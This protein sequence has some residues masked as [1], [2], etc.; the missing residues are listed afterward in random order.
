M[1]GKHLFALVIDAFIGI[2]C[3]FA[4]DES[5][6][7]YNKPI[8]AITFRGLN[9]IKS[10]DLE[11][12]THAFIGK[13]FDDEVFSDLLNRLFALNY[14]ES[15]DPVPY[16]GD[17][18][19]KTVKIELEVVEYPVVSKLKI[20]GYKKIRG[21]EIR[22]AISTKE[23]SI[24]DEDKRFADEQVIRN[25]YIS[26]GFSEAKVRSEAVQSEDGFSVTFTIKEGSQTVVKDIVFVGNTIATARTLKSKLSS[27]VHHLFQ[28]GAFQDA[29]IEQDKK[30]IVQ[31]YA[32]NG[33][34]DAKVLNASQS[35]EYNEKN[36][37]QEVTLQ[38]NIYE[39]SQYTY[40]GTTIQG[41]LVFSTDELLKLI[42]LKTGAVFNATKF[43]EGISA[44]QDKYYGSGYWNNEFVPQMER[45]SN[46]KVVS[47][48]IYIGEGLRSHVEG[49][50]I[51]GNTRTRDEVIRREIPIESGDV[52]SNE[53]INTAMRN[54]YNLQYFK[55]VIP[56]IKP[57][58]EDNL[59]IVEFSVEE[60][61]TRS[62]Q[63]GLTFSG[64]SSTGEFPIALF[65][66][67]EDTNLFGSGRTGSISTT[68]SKKEQSIT[69]GYG[70]NWI[71]N[72]PISNYVSFGYTRSIL[73]SPRNMLLP[74]G[75]FDFYSYFMEYTQHRFTVS[76]TISRRWTPSFANVTLS[77]GI[78]S[79]LI[80]NVYD[81]SLYVPAE[82]SISDY[83]NT[84][85]P[86]NSIFVQL[87]LDTRDNFYNPSKGWFASQ[88]FTWFGLMPRGKFIFPDSFG[89]SDFYLRSNTALEGYY[90]I[91]NA[92][93]TDSF[94]FKTILR[95][96][97]GLNMQRPF[98]NTSIKESN[99]LYLDGMVH[100]RG[101]E[102]YDESYA[103]GNLTWNNTV[104]LRIPIFPNAMAFDLFFDAS[105]V[106]KE[107][108]DYRDY[109]NMNDWY[110]SYGPGLSLT[111]Q[112]L[113]LR[114]FLAS[115]YKIDDGK[116]VYKDRD[117]DTVDNWL[118]S[119]HFVLSISMPNR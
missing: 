82:V 15:V 62:V 116:L 70:Q 97:T 99:Q 29:S 105:M 48:R 66:S 94:S 2:A 101:W 78:S 1:K 64:T 44:I 111:M 12:I 10:S 108:K 102:I 56:E 80:T 106:K 107:I 27:K 4:Q 34:I 114:L 85:N 7:Y 19:R 38:Y 9:N 13:R 109:S 53:K 25:L 55:K 113:P 17:K 41:N 98:F 18:D 59:G 6:W 23:K 42:K 35:T 24:Y 52:F 89:E 39:G 93:I 73:Q 83:H 21:S 45:D 84:W 71:F 112:Q 33:Y 36:D 115:N 67:L 117:G 58:S 22:D 76:D 65:G 100:A 60:Q 92:P 119:W 88:R 46:N 11:G 49:V 16:P 54:L 74:D 77:T 14:F 91:I 37:R 30:A 103:R 110:F 72:L 20:V 69:L 63:F 8:S 50:L 3:I 75:T 40:G 104:E 95:A 96:Y 43:Q 31:Y 87:S 32:D 90:T 47:Y 57:G 26:R 5:D 68:L 51:K 86:K 61:S 79:S 118:S 28:K 81:S